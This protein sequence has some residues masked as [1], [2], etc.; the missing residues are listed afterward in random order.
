MTAAILF[1][2]RALRDLEEI[3]Q[4]SFDNWGEAKADLYIG[5]IHD[6]LHLIAENTGIARHADD[7]RPGLWRYPAGSHLIFFRLSSST[8]RVVR[9]LHARMDVGRHI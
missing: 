9:I 1:S 4:Y 5:A 3:W 6:T 7:V 8:I 2:Q